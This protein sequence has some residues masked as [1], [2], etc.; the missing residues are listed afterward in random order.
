MLKQFVLLVF[1][2]VVTSVTAQELNC[3]VTV[4]ADQIS[5]SNN[6]VFKTLENALT[7][8]VNETEWTDIDFKEH[9]R[10]KSA[11]TITITEQSGTNS[12][13]GNIQIQASRPVFNS[14]YYTPI[15]NHKDNKFT[16]QY[17]EFQPINY[18]EN[19]FESN[20]VSTLSYYSYLII[21]LYTNTFDLEKSDVYLKQALAIA[22]QAQQSGAIGWKNT[23]TEVTRFTLID[24]LLTNSNEPFRKLF[25]KYHYNCLDDFEQ[26]KR[27][28]ASKLFKNLMTLKDIY[29][30]NP[31][32]IL[33]RML[34]DAKSDEI[35]NIYRK[36][37][38]INTTDLVTVLKKVSSNN[39]K[40]WK[41][42]YT[43]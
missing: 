29:D 21:G 9:E 1:L 2:G 16:F 7:S 12:F 13:S 10:I 4:N 11:M 22:N 30:E 35:V 42:I 20:L 14:S 40:K 6:R 24:Q 8:F 32:N 43:N 41:L 18:N 37:R 19:L 36:D 31:N 39:S 5:V 26:N 28:A 38:G 23:R 17:T 33:L 3:N 27:L 15:L 34:L 25:L